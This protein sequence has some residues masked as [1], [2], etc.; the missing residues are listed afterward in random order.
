VLRRVRKRAVTE[1]RAEGSGGLRGI[2]GRFVAC[3]WEK[4]GIFAWRGGSRSQ[5]ELFS[6]LFFL[7]VKCWCFECG[8]VGLWDSV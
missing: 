3:R 6:L 8:I 1:M 5:S 2:I 4:V 7:F